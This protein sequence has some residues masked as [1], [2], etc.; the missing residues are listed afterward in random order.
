MKSTNTT[1]VKLNYA[2]T[3]N[4]AVVRPQKFMGEISRFCADLPRKRLPLLGLS[5]AKNHF[6]SSVSE[7]LKAI[8]TQIMI[9]SMCIKAESSYIGF[10]MP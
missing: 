4:C 2:S 3:P 10:Y 7:K 9:D 8:A 6:P 5:V 1:F